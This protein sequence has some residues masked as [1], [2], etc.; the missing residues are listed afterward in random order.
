MMSLVSTGCKA[1]T[2]FVVVVRTS[3]VAK[4]TL[5]GVGTAV[6]SLCSLH[7]IAVAELSTTNGIPSLS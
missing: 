4:V 3:V 5:I 7:I 2:S 6:N 1:P